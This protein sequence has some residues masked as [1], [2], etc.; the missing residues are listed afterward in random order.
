MVNPS[1]EDDEIQGGSGSHQSS[2]GN[3]QCRQE[4][5][6]E[7]VKPGVIRGLEFGPY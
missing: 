3:I 1:R 2:D 7:G 6:R 5:D 4:R